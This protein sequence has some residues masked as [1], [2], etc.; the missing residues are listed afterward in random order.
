MQGPVCTSRLSARPVPGRKSIRCGPRAQNSNPLE[1]L[2]KTVQRAVSTKA[3]VTE[4]P[5]QPQVAARE[6]PAASASERLA[7][8]DFPQPP[9]ADKVP[10]TNASADVK[11]PSRDKAVMFQGK[12]ASRPSLQTLRA[13]A[14]R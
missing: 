5:K 14:R 10:K 7:K 12:P 1:A 2:Q 9:A 11:Q 6:K 3:A 8:G 13:V 4:A